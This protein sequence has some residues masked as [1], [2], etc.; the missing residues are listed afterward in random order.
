MKT[1]LIQLFFLSF[2]LTIGCTQGQNKTSLSPQMFADKISQTP[3]ALV[4]DVRTPGE[5][6][7]GH[8][9]KAK[10]I[11]WQGEH[12]EHQVMGLDKSK[13]VFV[14]CLKGGRSA[15]AA[16]KMRSMGFKEVYELE[17]GLDKWQAAKL[18]ITKD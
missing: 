11:D 3:E 16:S 7:E 8:L 13:P 15:S 17:G 2:A 18:P 5:Y 14:Y 1:R 12:F 10:N 6:V 4:I 9:A